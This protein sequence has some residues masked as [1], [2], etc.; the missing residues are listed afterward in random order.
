MK[1]K[2][3]PVARA[4][5]GTVCWDALLGGIAS[6]TSGDWTCEWDESS[7]ATPEAE[8]EDN[9]GLGP[10][11]DA[12]V[13]LGDDEA[14][15]WRLEWIVEDNGPIDCVPLLVKVDAQEVFEGV[16]VDAAEEPVTAVA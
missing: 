10:D 13:R 2:Y 1:K 14:A 5:C 7:A 16:D 8:A 15:S 11:A 4:A 3:S 6:D 12:C 9:K